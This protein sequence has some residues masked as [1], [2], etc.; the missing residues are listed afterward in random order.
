MVVIVS[1]VSMYGIKAYYG[2]LKNGQ[3]VRNAFLSSEINT[4]NIK[5]NTIRTLDKQKVDLQQRIALIEQLQSSRNLVTQLI[6]EVA[7]TV[8]SGVYLNKLERHEQ[9]INISGRSE[10]NNRLS[11]MLRQIE[12]SHLLERPT[13]QAIETDNESLKALS[14]FNMTFYIKPLTE[15]DEVNNEL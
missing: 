1:V 6:S 7:K 8:P 3:N 4:L 13:M 5:I 15:V 14:H 9:Q 2:A 11:A 12:H 10:S